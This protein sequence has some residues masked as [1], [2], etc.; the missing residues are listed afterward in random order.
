[1]V[2]RSPERIALSD[3]STVSLSRGIPGDTLVVP[4][5][6]SED[7]RRSRQIIVPADGRIEDVFIRTPEEKVARGDRL[8]LLYSPEAVAAQREY[9]LLDPGKDAALLPA[10][11]ERLIRMGLSADQVRAIRASGKVMERIPIR[12]PQAGYLLP[13]SPSANPMT[14]GGMRSG[15]QAMDQ[16]MG[17]GMGGGMTGMPGGDMTGDGSS[18]P[19]ATAAVPDG[20]GLGFLTGKY[21]SRG[22]VLAHVND[23]SRVAA[24]LSLPARALPALRVGDRVQISIPSLGYRGTTS[25]EFLEQRVADTGGNVQALAYLPNPKGRLKLGLLGKAQIH[26]QAEATWVL[27]RSAVHDLG[28]RQVVWVRIG[29]DTNR[30]GVFEAREIR[31]VRSGNRFVEVLEG[32]S[33][34]AEVAANA[35]LLLDPDA[36][37]DPV[38]LSAQMSISDA[39]HQDHAPA[40]EEHR[41]GP[42]EQAGVTE[43]DDHANHADDG[44]QT[45]P[46]DRGGH[47]E[48]ADKGGHGDHGPSADVL[49]LSEEKSRLAG[50]RSAVAETLLMVPSQVYRA[51]TRFD[52]RSR[53]TVPARSEGYIEQEKILRAGE[54]VREG[55]VLAFLVSEPFLAA[56]EEFLIAIRSA[57]ALSDPG[58]VRTQVQAA[59]RRLEVLGMSRQEILA[60][61]RRGSAIPRQ[62]IRAQRDGV[63]LEV[64]VQ[65]G[66]WVQEGDVLFTLGR[67]GRIWV[68][69]WLLSHEAALYPEG[70]DASVRLEGVPGEPIEGRIDHIRR[71]TSLSGSVALAHISIANPGNR[72]LPGMQAWVSFSQPGRRVLGIPASALIRSSEGAMIWVETERHTYAPRMV[73]IGSSTTDTVEVTRGLVPGE[74]VV[75]SGAYLLHSEWTIRKG[76]GKGHAGH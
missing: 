26:P 34:D 29:M 33:P 46:A 3:Q 1:M 23:L 16:P 50:I 32:L 74:R 65:P 71:R 36:V 49:M 20:D 6:I 37:L 9:L 48:Q 76:A 39:R 57:A 28:D 53:E 18:M 72:I 69:T 68:E 45:G 15:G 59:R 38:P 51:I 52:D 70:T 22:E 62:P 14:R 31:A 4:A 56:Q 42:G 17:G 47:G 24:V 58:L 19:A 5:R 2:L 41:H 8:A 67:T 63:L 25:L 13:G 40:P 35:S 55:Q 64:K 43:H 60:L 21:V 66:Q 12:S 75:V 10:A 61:E 30:T 73:V 11:V 27:P 7:E 44:D 54:A